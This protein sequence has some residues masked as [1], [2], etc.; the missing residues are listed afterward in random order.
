MQFAGNEIHSEWKS[1]SIRGT[2]R[3]VSEQ[4]FVRLTFGQ[5]KF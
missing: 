4:K 1:T 2:K 5:L 3:D